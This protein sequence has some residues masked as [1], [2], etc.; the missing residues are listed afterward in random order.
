MKSLLKYVVL[1][2]M[3]LAVS[4]SGPAEDEGSAMEADKTENV[5]VMELQQREV[6]RTVDYTGTLLAWE[7]FHVAPA[8]PGRIAL[9]PVEVGTRVKK[10]AILAEMDKTQLRQ[11][12]LQLAN[13]RTDF[14]RLDTLRKTGSIA[15]Q[16]YDQIKTQYEITQSNVS[17]LKENAVL[18][19]PFAGVISGKYY[20]QGEIYSGAPNPMTGKAAIV[21]LVQIDRLKITVPVSEQFFP[22]IKTG[23]SAKIVTD[24]YPNKV[25]TGNIFNIHP[26]IDPATR[27]FNIEISVSNAGNLLR[28]GMFCRVS[29][30]LLR[31]EALLLPANA[32]LKMQGSNDRFLF[33]EEN[34]IAV[35]VPVTLGRRYDDLVEVFSERLNK[36]DRVIV[37]GQPRLLD[38]VK[39][40]VVE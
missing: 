38:G 27:T 22:N 16:Q 29:L 33:V 4:C 8:Q 10:G 23:M 15:K 34:G 7:E 31:V 12:E 5:R 9:I 18:K 3:V 32:V 1:P 17:F 28:P 11:A 25:F 36:G 35:R 21:S 19:A 30:D 24:I 20:E 37:S 40:N 26:T 14:N 39:V 2:A 13:L 6:A